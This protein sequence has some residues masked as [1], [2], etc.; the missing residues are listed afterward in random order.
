VNE[1]RAIT[2]DDDD[3][4]S[5][6]STTHVA[7]TLHAIGQKKPL[8]QMTKWSLTSFNHKTIPTLW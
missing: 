7:D 5:F 2:S 4:A 6:V 8:H 1:V 3:H